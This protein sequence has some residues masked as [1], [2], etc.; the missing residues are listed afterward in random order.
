ME[1]L[2]VLIIIGFLILSIWEVVLLPKY[3]EKKI[4][5]EL[6]EKGS[7]LADL[8]LISRRDCIYSVSYL[9]NDRLVRENVKYGLLGRIKWI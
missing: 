8:I 2:R 1:E 4:V 9:K 5:L 6:H 7:E 3:V